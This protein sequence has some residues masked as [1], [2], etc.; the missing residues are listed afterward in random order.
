MPGPVAKKSP[1][2]CYSLKNGLITNLEITLQRFGLTA[3]LT[4]A[5]VA[6]IATLFHWHHPWTILIFFSAESL[7]VYLLVSRKRFS[8]LNADILYWFTVVG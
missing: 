3:G 2:W 1:C 8:L 5:L 7:L 6:S 4:A